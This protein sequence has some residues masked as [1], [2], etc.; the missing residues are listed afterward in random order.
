MINRAME[1]LLDYM[2]EIPFAN[3]IDFKK[4][5]KLAKEINELSDIEKQCPDDH[6][7]YDIICTWINP[8]YKM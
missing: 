2:D 5:R 8:K 7:F 4:I 1:E 3:E 6:E